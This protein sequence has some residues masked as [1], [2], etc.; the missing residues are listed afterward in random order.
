MPPLRLLFST[1]NQARSFNLS[2]KVV[3]SRPLSICAVFWTSYSPLF[4]FPAVQCSQKF[5]P[6][7]A[8][9]QCCFRWRH[10]LLPLKY[11][12]HNLAFHCAIEF[13]HRY[14]AL[15]TRVHPLGFLDPSFQ[16]IFP[17]GH[18]HTAFWSCAP[19][20]LQLFPFYY[21]FLL[22]RSVM[23]PEGRESGLPVDLAP[24]LYIHCQRRYSFY[25]PCP[26]WLMPTREDIKWIITWNYCP[27]WRQG[28]SAF[29]DVAENNVS[30]LFYYFMVQISSSFT[31][32]DF[33]LS[34]HINSLL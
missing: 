33:V 28:T 15:L 20:C 31:H 26:K 1:L 29:N 9:Y 14:V 13:V 12:T 30:L 8:L 2:S 5:T 32:L 4:L 34:G 23:I 11:A 6:V 22:I 19:N 10:G 21:Y 17:T 3:F 16:L 24:S 27:Q 18:H 25:F 7:P